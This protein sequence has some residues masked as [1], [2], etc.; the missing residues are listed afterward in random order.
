VINAAPAGEDLIGWLSGEVAGR[1]LDQSDGDL[2]EASNR[3][4]MPLADLRKLL[5]LKK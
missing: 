5:A 2:K 4:N 3:I 1:I